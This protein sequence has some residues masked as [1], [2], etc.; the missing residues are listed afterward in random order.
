MKLLTQLS[1]GLSHLKKSQF[2]QLRQSFCTCSLDVKSISYFFL[3]FDHYNLLSFTLFDELKTV[4]KKQP[5]DNIT[6]NLFYGGTKFKDSQ[7]PSYTR[8]LN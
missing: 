7:K 4:Q 2:W 3:H 6:K 8:L 1:F 5:N